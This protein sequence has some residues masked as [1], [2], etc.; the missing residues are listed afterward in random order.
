M[1][2]SPLPFNYRSVFSDN[3]ICLVE[4]IHKNSLIRKNPH[5]LYGSISATG[6]PQS[7]SISSQ[8]TTRL[9]ET[10]HMHPQAKIEDHA[11]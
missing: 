5:L 2:F 1:I 4:S 7:C 10:P 9:I 11:A 8:A 6:R 3:L